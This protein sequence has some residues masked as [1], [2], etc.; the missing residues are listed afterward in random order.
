MM[1]TPRASVPGG[2]VAGS[3]LHGGCA[4]LGPVIPPGTATTTSSSPLDGLSERHVPAFTGIIELH[5]LRIEPL[6]IKSAAEPPK[7]ALVLLVGGV[8]H[9]G[10]EVLVP[11][12]APA[13]LGWTR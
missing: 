1:P 13:V 10:H 11:T 8:T 12:D 9:H 3:R 6:R 2:I 7:S 4:C 5:L